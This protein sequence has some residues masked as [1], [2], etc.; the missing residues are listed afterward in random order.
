MEKI[1]TDHKIWA[2]VAYFIFFLPL[3]VVEV[4]KNDFV[5]FHIRQ[6]LGFFITFCVLRI[7]T[8]GIL[9]PLFAVFGWLSLFL[10]PITNVLLLVLLV[11]GI[12][13]A[14]SGEKRALPVIG[15]WFEKHLKI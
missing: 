15:E 11:M 12:I 3:L 6:G 7:L 9:P 2:V 14:V 1:Q 13:N 5:R 4:K 10:V 8:L